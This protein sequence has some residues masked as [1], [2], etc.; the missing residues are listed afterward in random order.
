MG[1]TCCRKVEE[2]PQIYI[3]VGVDDDQLLLYRDE[4]ESVPIS[5]LV[6]EL[7]EKA[8]L[9]VARYHRLKVPPNFKLY[10]V[11][12][13][14]KTWI[15]IPTKNAVGGQSTLADLPSFKVRYRTPGPGQQI[16][17]QFRKEPGSC[18]QHDQYIYTRIM[19]HSN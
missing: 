16:D 12:P 11:D 6:T 2:K 15:P 8:R 1:Q 10:V 9:F 7:N 19:E 5:T 3:Y 4:S 17:F 18:S 14:A 13:V